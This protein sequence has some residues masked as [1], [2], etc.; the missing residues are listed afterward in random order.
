MNNVS[1]IYIFDFENIQTAINNS[2]GQEKDILRVQH[3]IYLMRLLLFKEK[4]FMQERNKE[5]TGSA[6]IFSKDEKA[7]INEAENYIST[8]GK[9][10]LRAAHYNYLM[11]IIN[12]IK[13]DYRNAVLF[14]GKSL[15][16]NEYPERIYNEIISTVYENI[17]DDDMLKKMLKEKISMYPE[18][19]DYLLLGEI[20]FKNNNLSKAAMLCQQA[21][22]FSAD[23]PEAYSA[24]A[25]IFAKDENYLAADEM[26]QKAFTVS[27]DS[28]TMNRS[29]KIQIKVNEAAIALLKKENERAYVLLRSVLNADNDNKAGRLYHRFFNMDRKFQ[30]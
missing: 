28:Y 23:Y 7:V 30:K 2:S 29:L 15:N 12:Y 8:T 5:T 9:K 19:R 22:K 26:I 17:N 21:L 16:E 25:V 10:S 13:S 6:D 27:E 14:F 24:L 4:A 11:G 20:E 3:Y 18:A 1:L